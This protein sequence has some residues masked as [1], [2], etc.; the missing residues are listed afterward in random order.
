[1]APTN[2]AATNGGGGTSSGGEVVADFAFLL[3]DRTSQQAAKTLTRSSDF[4]G[5]NVI[6]VVHFYD[7]G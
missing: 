2:S 7:G 3:V 6:T 1:M 4:M 5:N